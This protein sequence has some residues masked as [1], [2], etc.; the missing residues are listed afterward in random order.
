[1]PNFAKNLTMDEIVR[2]IVERLKE[3]KLIRYASRNS[4]QLAAEQ[5]QVNFPCALVD[6]VNVEYEQT[7]KCGQIGTADIEF[8]IADIYSSR[9]DYSVLTVIDSVHQRLQGWRTHLFSPLIRLSLRRESNLPGYDE[10]VATY[11]TSFFVPKEENFVEVS[12]EPSVL[13]EDEASES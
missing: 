5:P 6:I 3:E 11:R 1:M 10:Y 7:G 2:L 13:V 9:H 12:V 8:S 4:G